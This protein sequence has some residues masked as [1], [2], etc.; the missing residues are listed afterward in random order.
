MTRAAIA[1]QDPCVL[2]EA[3]ELYQTQGS[4]YCDAPTEGVGGARFHREGGDVT[5]ITWGPMVH[6][7][8]EASNLLAA[9]DIDAGVLDLRWLSPLDE[10]AIAEA[11]A[12]SAGRL[13]VAHEANLTGGFGAEIVAG[14]HERH[15]QSLS[16]PV[17][18][19]GAPD[20][21]VPAAAS[22]QRAVI[23]G[24]DQIERIARQLAST[25]GPLNG[26]S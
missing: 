2:I 10:A 23:P 4:V 15:F 26:R 13:L 21:R 22:L 7:A 24:V 16:H 5:I 3:R 17:R 25:S 6:R 20:I 14:I 8:L 1:D 19:L 9:D 18:R 11:V 12:M